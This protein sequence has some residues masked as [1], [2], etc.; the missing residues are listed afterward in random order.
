MILG[1][2]IYVPSKK[3]VGYVSKE[4][5]DI[6]YPEP[7]VTVAPTFEVHDG[8]YKVTASRLNMREGPSTSYAVKTTLDN[9]EQVHAL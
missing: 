2:K 3:V 4:Y 6:T 5:L 9:G 7:T 1:C 8:I